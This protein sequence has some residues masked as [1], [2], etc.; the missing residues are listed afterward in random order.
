[1]K[2]VDHSKKYKYEDGT[3]RPDDKII[4]FLDNEFVTGFKEDR[5]FY[6]KDFDIAM[7]KKIKEE[8]MTY[9]QAYNALGFDTRVLGE[10]R[11]NAAGKRVMEKARQNKLFTIDESSYDGSVP[12]DEMGNLTPEEERA[13]LKARTRYLEE[14][15]L[16][17]KKIR[18]ELEEFF[19]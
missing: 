4:P 5:L 19:T 9:V 14:M 3:D 12:R 1:M 13:Y 7:Y 6:S 17:Q 8:G 10:N 16:A 2:L 18:S 15:L 11:A